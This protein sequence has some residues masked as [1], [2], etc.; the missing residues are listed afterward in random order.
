MEERAGRVDGVAGIGLI[1]KGDYLGSG[2]KSFSHSGD[3]L[4]NSIK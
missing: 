2:Y 3:S 4:L 1:D